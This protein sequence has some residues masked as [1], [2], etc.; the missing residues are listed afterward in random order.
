MDIVEKGQIQFSQTFQELRMDVS[1]EMKESAMIEGVPF[2][3]Q[4]P[5]LE[6]GCEVTSLAMLLQY[7]GV[8]VDKMELA[9][10]IKKVPFQENGMRG[11]PHEGFVGD[12]Y[13]KRNPGYGVYHQP[14]FALGQK[15][16]PNGLFNLTGRD[17]E[18]IY[19]AI[20]MGT[21]VWVIT[22]A[23][24]VPLPESEFQTWQ[25]S[26]G[27]VK[28]TYHEH[29]VVIVGYDQEYVYVNDPLAKEPQTAISRSNFEKAWRQ[30]G[31]QAISLSP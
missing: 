12:I 26:A 5:E 22:N 3:R 27:E 15:Y 7:G 19:K 23:E 17:V 11:N 21:P 14:I 9:R 6:R 29:S 2:I 4:M 31:K 18:D 10:Q 20:S 8:N 1:L 30:M 28:I 13:T 24:F 16:L 25:T